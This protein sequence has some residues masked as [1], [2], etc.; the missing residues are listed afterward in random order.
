MKL[1]YEIGQADLKS[2]EK[3]IDGKKYIMAEKVCN[4][5][6]SLFGVICQCIYHDR[7][8]LN[9]YVNSQCPN[10]LKYIETIKTIYWPDWN[11]HIR[12]KYSS[13]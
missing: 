4:E 1:V 6:A 12:E 2:I 8:P 13:P 7:G 10:I 3:F 9:Q 11:D 5:D